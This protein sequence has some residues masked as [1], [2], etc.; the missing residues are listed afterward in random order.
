MTNIKDAHVAILCEMPE[1]IGSIVS[2]LRDLAEYKYGDLT[3]YSGY[4]E[5]KK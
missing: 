4:F 1:E 2:N 3:I 5:N